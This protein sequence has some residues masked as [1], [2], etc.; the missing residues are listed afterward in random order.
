MRQPK[1]IQQLNMTLNLLQNSANSA[2]AQIEV[3][4]ETLREILPAFEKSHKSHIKKLM[5]RDSANRRLLFD[6]GHQLSTPIIDLLDSVYQ[7]R[8]A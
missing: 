1:E 8:K 2:L 5:S 3:L 6:R 7:R 4:T